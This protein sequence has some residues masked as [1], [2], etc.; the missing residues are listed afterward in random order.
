MPQLLAV[1]E[2]GVHRRTGRERESLDQLR[3]TAAPGWSNHGLHVYGYESVVTVKHARVWVDVS[4]FAFVCMFLTFESTCRDVLY[5]STRISLLCTFSRTHPHIYIYIY[6]HLYVY[7][8]IHALKCIPLQPPIL[9]P[10]P[11]KVCLVCVLGRLSS[12]TSTRTNL[13]LHI[14]KPT[15]TE[16]TELVALMDAISVLSVLSVLSVAESVRMR[17]RVGREAEGRAPVSADIA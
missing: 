7:S 1:G 10:P 5:I 15:C 12:L 11:L 2:E 4:I 17:A 16:A 6:I 13:P 3:G 8:H 14:R 9:P